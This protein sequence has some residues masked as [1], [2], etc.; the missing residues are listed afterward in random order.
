MSTRESFLI[1][2][3]KSIQRGSVTATN[4]STGTVTVT[5]VDTAKSM[6]QTS[7]MSGRL[8]HTTSGTPFSGSA[9]MTLTNTT[10]LTWYAPA[11]TGSSTVH[12]VIYWQL[13]EYK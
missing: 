7:V 10:T 8:D 3:I 9:G 12:S 4:G 13:V 2:P 1:S 5:A 6:L 11:Q